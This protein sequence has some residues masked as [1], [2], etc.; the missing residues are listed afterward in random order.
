MTLQQSVLF[1]ITP[2][3]PFFGLLLHK[4]RIASVDKGLGRFE[5]KTG[6]LHQL[7]GDESLHLPNCETIL[8]IALHV[9]IVWHFINTTTDQMGRYKP[10]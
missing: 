8:A 2:S 5:Y 1:F 9:S 10:S 7:S 4:H 3:T 6:E